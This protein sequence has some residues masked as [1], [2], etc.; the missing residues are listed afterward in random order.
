MNL[1]S[2]GCLWPGGASSVGDSLFSE[3]HLI[4]SSF[5]IPLG[6]LIPLLVFQSA[7][8]SGSAEIVSVSL[9]R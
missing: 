6:S 4:D 2:S 3:C 5:V 9:E 1:G 8:I 7:K